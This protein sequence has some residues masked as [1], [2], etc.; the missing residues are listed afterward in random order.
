MPRL[1]RIANRPALEALETRVVL[2]PTIYTVDS[3]GNST[4]GAGTSGTL[5]YA[6]SLANADT[7]P[8]GSEVTFDPTVSGPGSSWSPAT[9]SS[10]YSAIMAR[11][12]SRG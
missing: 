5:P 3:T 10:A 12:P 8:D 6:I 11:R 1:R 2:S 4:A 9:A 7:N